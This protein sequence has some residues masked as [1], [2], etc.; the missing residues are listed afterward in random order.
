MKDLYLSYEFYIFHIVFC[1]V[2][3]HY[4]YIVFYEI[5]NENLAYPSLSESFYV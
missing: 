5:Y 1:L 4:K 2:I 3:R